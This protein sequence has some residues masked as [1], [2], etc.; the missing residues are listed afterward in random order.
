MAR[1]FAPQ[2]APASESQRRHELAKLVA[3][4]DLYTWK[5]LRQDMSLDADQTRAAITEIAAAITAG[6]AT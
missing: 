3:A 2:L 5:V 1:V 4:T 6:I